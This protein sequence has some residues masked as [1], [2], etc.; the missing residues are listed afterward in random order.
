[1]GEIMGKNKTENLTDRNRK[2]IKTLKKVID[3]LII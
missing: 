2:K 1:M 3:N